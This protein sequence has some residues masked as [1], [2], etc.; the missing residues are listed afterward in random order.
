[1][2]DVLIT[3]A[4]GK[5][6]FKDGS[7]NI[8]AIIE[9]DGAGN[10]NISSPG[11]DIAIGDTTS[12][13]FIGDGVNNIDII[14]EQNG[15]IRGTTGVTLT[16]GQSDSFV[17]LGTDLDTVSFAVKDVNSYRNSANLT[18]TATTTVSLYEFSTGTY[19]SGEFLIQ[20]TQ[21]TSRH[22]TKMAVVANSTVA[23]ATEYATLLTASSLFTTD[24]DV[25]TGTAR[26]RITPASATSTVFRT[27]F[28]LITA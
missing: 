24:V 2:T 28:E 7:G 27:T 25:S 22:V 19:G 5:I 17:K 11:G 18:T 12:D 13:L 6:E 4:S 23:S 9:L 3:P 26:V 14:F 10:L 1:M 20:A 16:L 8:D 15:E 21:G